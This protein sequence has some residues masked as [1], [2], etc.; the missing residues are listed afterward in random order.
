MDRMT[1]KIV[2][3]VPDGWSTVSAI[4][5]CQTNFRWLR[6]E[7]RRCLDVRFLSSISFFLQLVFPSWEISAKISFSWQRWIFFHYLY[8]GKILG[9][10]ED[11][12]RRRGR[13]S[14]KKLIKRAIDR[15]MTC[16]VIISTPFLAPS[17]IVVAIHQEKCMLQWKLR[18]TAMAISNT[19][20]MWWI[21]GLSRPGPTR[22]RQAIGSEKP[23]RNYQEE[24]PGGWLGVPTRDQRETSNLESGARVPG[25][26]WL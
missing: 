25:S 9:L 8:A 20:V 21:A 18:G 5:I 12:V 2:K 22:T 24:Q 10:T 11:R 26:W 23:Q 15:V 7:G 16:S 4:C 13:K 6:R 19:E 1:R 3:P 17:V 14:D